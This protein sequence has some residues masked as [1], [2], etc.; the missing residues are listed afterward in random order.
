[1]VICS[2][3]V[4]PETFPGIKFNTDGVCIYCQKFEGKR[5]QNRFNEDKDRYKKKFLQL[6]SQL[7]RVSQQ[8]DFN[9]GNQSGHRSYDVL[10]A[11]SGGK[12]S[13][14]T[15]KILKKD[16]NL[17]ILAITFN[18]GF[19]SEKAL[20][21]I[22]TITGALD[23]DH[24]MFSPNQAFLCQA[25]K[26]SLHSDVYSLK[27]LE[28]ASSVCNTCMNMTKA[29]LLKYSIMLGIPMIG[30]GWSPGQ[31]PIQSS[32]MKWNLTMLR[33]TQ[34]VMS[35][36]FKKIMNENWN[37]FTIGPEVFDCFTKKSGTDH[38]ALLYN[39][40]PLA[41]LDY[42]E[43]KI[44]ED[45]KRLGWEDPEDTDSNSTNCLLNGYANLVHA[46]RYGFHPYAFEI[47]GLVRE[48]YMTREAGLAKLSIGP[49]EEIVERV[50]SKLG[51]R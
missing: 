14:Y 6:V 31:A 35:H 42:D 28:R 26:Q 34:E 2:N 24:I 3:C 47:G 23:V 38:G 43:E 30:Y 9:Q 12:D 8:D 19:V 36:N 44:I 25:F 16:F 1:M 13:S 49:N 51:I 18:H 41:F 17:K 10:M 32:V 21:N 5:I 40:H 39:I 11:F 37:A 4:L 48:G 33:Q 50:K 7:T 22:K 15:L 46:E 20:E 45:I 27:T 29:I